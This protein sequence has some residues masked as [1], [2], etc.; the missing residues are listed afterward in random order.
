MIIRRK[1][2]AIAFLEI[3]SWGLFVLIAWLTYDK[4]LPLTGNVAKFASASY[5]IIGT[6]LLGIQIFGNERAIAFDN[7]IYENLTAIALMKSARYL[8]P[9][10]LVPLWERTT[11]RIKNGMS[12]GSM[13]Y[14][15]IIYGLFL[16]IFA[17]AITR[18]KSI[19]LS[20]VFQILSAC[21]GFFLLCMGL[22]DI[23]GKYKIEYLSA[24]AGILLLV[25]SY[26]LT[27]A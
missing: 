16:P 26:V 27:L 11:A 25:M 20:I 9:G 5:G 12:S 7:W 4:L 2:L 3:M 17:I 21:V 22:A 14:I 19:W 10:E 18:D 6:L 8:R 15:N 24:I 1:K 13:S 23:R